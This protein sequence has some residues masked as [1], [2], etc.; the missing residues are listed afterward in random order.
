MLSIR[1]NRFLEELEHAVRRGAVILAELAGYGASCDAYHITA[2]D[3]TGAGM[4]FAMRRA[5][6]CAE[7]PPDEISCIYAHGTGTKANDRCE[8]NAVHDVF[9]SRTGQIKISAVKSMIGHAI[10]AA[11]AQAAAA[12]VQT[13]QTNLV[14]PVLNYETPDPECMLN[15]T[16]CG[17]AEIDAQA[18]MI[19]SLGFGGHNAVLIFRRWK[20]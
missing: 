3:P 7:C 10:S 2:P 17:C 4:S 9:G 14:P 19:S 18:A 15:I 11:G 12:A 20:G 6:D 1:G 5:L 8:S 16:S 13:L